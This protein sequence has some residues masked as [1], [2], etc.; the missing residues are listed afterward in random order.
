VPAGL[1]RVISWVAGLTLATLAAAA[2][3]RVLASAVRAAPLR[4]LQAWAAALGVHALLV[5]M[6]AVAI[7]IL[8]ATARR[9]AAPA[10][11]GRVLGVLAAAAAL[12]VLSLMGAEATAGPW[13]S[14]QAWAPV[15]R[16]GIAVVG[17]AAIGLSAA[18]LQ[19]VCGDS[20]ARR[21]T[22]TAL[23]FG[24][25]IGCAWA[26]LA[27]DPERFVIAH[28][29][30]IALAA[31]AFTAG[32]LRVYATPA[33]HRGG[34]IPLVGVGVVVVVG[35]A[36]GWLRMTPAVRAELLLHAPVTATVLRMT[37]G[38]GPGRL[39]ALLRTPAPVFEDGL[40]I[41]P[42]TLGSNRAQLH[43]P[44]DVSIVLVTVDALRADALPPVRDADSHPAA[45]GDTPWLDAFVQ[46]STA[47]TH[48]YAQ[49][50]ITAASMPVMFRSVR[51][52]ESPDRI[53]R[54]LARVMADHD[55]RPL[56]VVNDWFVEENV[57]RIRA[58]L[59]GFARVEIYA[60]E[61]MDRAIP[62]AIDLVDEVA[63]E[64]FV[65]WIHLFALHAPGYDGRVLDR[66]DGSWPERYRRSLRWVDGQ[67]AA[68]DAA[69]AERGLAERTIVV[70]ASDHGE[71]LGD[72]GVLR[73]GA[74]VF[75][76]EVRVPLVVR[77]PGRPGAVRETTIGN[78]DL[79]PT[80]VDLLGGA[81][82]PAHRGRSLVPLLLDPAAAWPRAYYM[83]NRTGE[84]VALVRARDK[85]VWDRPA[86]AAMRF[87]LQ[88]DPRETA[89]VFTGGPDD[90]RLLDRLFRLDPE[91]LAHELQDV[92][93]R[94]LLWQRMRSIDAR[95]PDGDL[96]FLLRLSALVEGDEGARIGA[97]R[98]DAVGASRVR[99]RL[100]AQFFAEDPKAWSR[101]LVRWLRGA[102]DA[103][104]L[105]EAL[106]R[107][108]QPAFASKWVAARLRER[109]AESLDAAR[110]WLRLVAG[111]RRLP[112]AA[113][114]EPLA[115]VL[116]RARTEDDIDIASAGLRAARRVRG[117]ADEH[118]GALALADAID[119]FIDHPDAGLQVEAVR[120]LARRGAPATMRLREVVRATDRAVHVRQA[121]LR[122]IARARGPTVIDLIEEAGADPRLRVDAIHLLRDTGDPAAIDALTRLRELPNDAK[123]RRRID[124]AI[125]TL[126]SGGR[127]R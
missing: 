7:G 70:L 33:V 20:P 88:A 53:G 73:H 65:L 96:D 89:S 111:W 39:R 100:V 55:R 19:V 42:P 16:H 117:M 45:P 60:P 13:I 4:S 37:A 6:S 38:D 103:D 91:L 63:P 85:I 43:L 54:P 61:S 109:A 29:V 74:T 81:P 102:D 30:A 124:A 2:T 86:H 11:T 123:T 101:R 24:V 35:G 116:R 84:Q 34:V 64:P 110:P 67:L 44:A 58:M 99:L 17:G 120:A 28:R 62:L 97:E 59:D 1:R 126:R 49:A 26:D 77:I 5:A 50:T 71:G 36:V 75:E 51:T 112:R 14:A 113:F 40:D 57:P 48:V 22:I 105:A 46:Q 108:G 15:L 80:L 118:P 79:V 12:P 83:R 76:E 31:L 41:E 125:A 68:L 72:N 69:L 93:T 3:D 9:I 52:F 94:E 10:R 47:F 95:T 115:D 121:A 56:A 127:A 106:A 32:A 90:Q 78:V 27:L 82:D 107:Q 122:V 119:P 114:A 98:F 25:G 92:E 66:G 87:D 18:R 8:L 23:A 21:R 104:A